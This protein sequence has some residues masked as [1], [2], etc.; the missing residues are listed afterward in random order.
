MSL[1]LGYDYI[2]LMTSYHITGFSVLLEKH[3][4]LTEEEG[5]QKKQN[6]RN[7]YY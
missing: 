5:S 3:L 1:I 4:L 7:C 6:Y 2:V